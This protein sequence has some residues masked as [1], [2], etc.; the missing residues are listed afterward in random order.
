MSYLD[1]FRPKLQKGI[2]IFEIST[3]E[4]VKNEF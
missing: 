2:V 1:I 4:F 3:L